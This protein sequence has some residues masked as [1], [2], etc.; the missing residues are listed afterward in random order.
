MKY[1][2]WQKG[3]DAALEAGFLNTGKSCEELVTLDD[4][5][6]DDAVAAVEAFLADRNEAD[7]AFS[8]I[9]GIPHWLHVNAKATAMREAQID[10]LL[11]VVSRAL[12]AHI[13][14]QT[15]APVFA[16]LGR[17]VAGLVYDQIEPSLTDRITS[18]SSFWDEAPAPTNEHWLAWHKD[19]ATDSRDAS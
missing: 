3:V 1:E 10:G 6:A 14:E 16:E 7:E 4:L 12:E 9:V 13:W 2:D 8:G 5:P 11:R 18:Q 19:A 17:L 15:E